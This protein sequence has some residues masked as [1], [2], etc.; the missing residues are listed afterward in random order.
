MIIQLLKIIFVIALLLG[1]FIFYTEIY[2]PYA[3]ASE[4]TETILANEGIPKNLR[5][6]NQYQPQA[7]KALRAYCKYGAYEKSPY[8]YG[9]VPNS[10]VPYLMT[11]FFGY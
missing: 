1:G 10:P 3:E 11:K 2:R 6:S 9:C 4:E 8:D 7:M 5:A